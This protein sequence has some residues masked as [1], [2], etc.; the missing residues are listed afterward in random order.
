[1]H[2]VPN[3]CSC[4]L[5]L[6]HLA[7]F[8]SGSAGMSWDSAEWSD[9]PDCME[10]NSDSGLKIPFATFVSPTPQ[11]CW[12]TF[13]ILWSLKV[14]SHITTQTHSSP[15]LVIFDTLNTKQAV[16]A[17]GYF[18]GSLIPRVIFSLVSRKKNVGFVHFCKPMNSC[19]STLFGQK[20][21]GC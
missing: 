15:T 1:M 8:H 18:P 3:Q 14:T 12:H 4:I 16:R 13:H 11:L 5:A 7:C 6:I 10:H 17:R 21:V 9:R 2:C 20:N 19:M